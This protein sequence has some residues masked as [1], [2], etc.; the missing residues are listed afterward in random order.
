MTE[1][2]KPEVVLVGLLLSG[3]ILI[4]F[5]HTLGDLLDIDLVEIGYLFIIVTF[6]L[7]IILVLAGVARFT[8]EL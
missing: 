1:V 2:T 4:F 6:F 7:G 3:I 5:G 8:G